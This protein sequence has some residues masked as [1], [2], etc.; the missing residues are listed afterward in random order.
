MNELLS[1]KNRH[2]DQT[3]YLQSVKSPK[4]VHDKSDEIGNYKPKQRQ[5]E[6]PVDI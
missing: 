1:E 3:N 4:S 2:L 5:R 6:K